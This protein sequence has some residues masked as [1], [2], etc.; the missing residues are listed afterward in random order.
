[1]RDSGG[2]RL[3]SILQSAEHLIYVEDY[4]LEPLLDREEIY[5]AV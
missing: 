2:D 5:C 3:R 1:M 4:Y